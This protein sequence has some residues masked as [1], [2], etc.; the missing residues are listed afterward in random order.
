MSHRRRREKEIE[1]LLEELTAENFLN[2]SKEM[3]I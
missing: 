1:N 3:G 2:Q